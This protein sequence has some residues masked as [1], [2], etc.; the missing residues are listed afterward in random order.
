MLTA[1]KEHIASNFPWL[2]QK[3]LLIACSGGL[4][5]VVLVSLLKHYNYSFAL[6]H[7]NFGLRGTESDGDEDFVS[8]LAKKNDAQFHAKRFDTK[9]YASTSKQSTQMA[10]RS[11]RY[12]WFEALCVENQYDVVL[13]AHHADD[14]LETFLINL[15]RGTGIKG[16]T[17]INSIHDR[18]VRVLLPF[19]RANILA[20]ASKNQLFWREDSSN[21]TTNYLRN[22]LRHEVIPPYKK[23]TKGLLKSVQK[24]QSYLLASQALVQ[25]Y[26]ALIYNLVV[27]EGVDGLEIDI[28]QVKE[29]PNT[30][31]L[32]YEL[33]QPYGF[34]ARE[35]VTSLLL[36]QSGK[37]LYSNTHRLL[38]DRK[39]LILTERTPKIYEK[40]EV[41]ENVQKK[42]LKNETQIDTPVR[43]SFIPTD[44]MGYIDS[45]AVYV[46]QDKLTFP[47][48]VRKWQKGDV[49]QP[50]GMKGKKKLSKF[51]KDEKLSLAAKEKVWLLCSENRI[52]WI[53][54]MRMDDRFKVT[55]NTTKIVQV[56]YTPKQ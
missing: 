5:S 22:Q 25:D 40:L 48:I 3:K 6:A 2:P 38:K 52:I 55:G 44:K 14:D 21:A 4:D 26:M 35:D 18:V 39:K 24:T 41:E 54:G 50:F 56:K 19:S 17:G 16:L 32:L 1:F 15:S 9:A 27:S 46:D 36:A 51:F 28:E 33:L 45:T 13:T 7:C 20:Y 47:L 31:S 49:F 8:D 53:I 42:I 30:N 12:E 43:L 37:K 10:A 23:A 34:T 11:L 29:L